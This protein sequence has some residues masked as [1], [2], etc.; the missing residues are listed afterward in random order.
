MLYI[1][2][3]KNSSGECKIPN[4]QDRNY[5][6]EIRLSIIT[7]NLN[8]A[9]GL[10]K[11]IGSVK[12]QTYNNFEFIIIDGASTDASIEIIKDNTFLLSYWISE[13]D[14]GTYHAM[15]KGLKASVGEYCLFLNSGDYFTD[16]NVLENIFKQ[17]I[18]A[19]I[20]S[21]NVLKMRPNNKFRR[22]SSH[23]S[24]SLLK[25]CIHSLPHQA[26]LI[27]RSLFDEIGNYN[28][29]Y[30]IVSDWEF[31]LKALVINEKSYQ[32]IDVDIS[33]FKIGGI[34]SSK[35]NFALSIEE[36]H[37]CLKRNFPKMGDD[38]M[39]YRL[40]FNSN[41]GQIVSLIKKKKRLYNLID[42]ICGI[43]LKSKK[44]LAGK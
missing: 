24:V 40:F 18:T 42:K 6:M 15:N 44:T 29:S 21:G 1:Y 10:E 13:P 43:M 34:S 7:V 31:F 23:E 37:D 5:I 27:R 12:A 41:F 20:V 38:L 3:L 19:D 11:T 22:V 17:N 30:R 36:S 8:N 9:S 2:G 4:F 25:L 16:N 32:H 33:Y 26:S 14:S 28:E 35:E 39:E